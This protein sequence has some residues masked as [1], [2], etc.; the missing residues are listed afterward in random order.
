MNWTFTDDTL[1][2]PSGRLTVLP[3]KGAAI[4][5]LSLGDKPPLLGTIPHGAYMTI[6]WH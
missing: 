5:G 1:T 6:T 2:T 4:A 3:D